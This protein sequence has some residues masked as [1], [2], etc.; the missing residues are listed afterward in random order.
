[1]KMQIIL[2]GLS[3]TLAMTLFIELI[4]AIFKK[5]FHVV[6]ILARM[7]SDNNESVVKKNITYCIA[8]VVHYSI[9]V[10]FAYAFHFLVKQDLIDP[11]L[12][13]ALLFGAL[14]GLVGILGWRMAF[15]LHP[16]P[17]V[18]NRPHYLFV[19]WIGHLIFAMGT[20]IMYVRLSLPPIEA[21]IPVC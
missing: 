11:T 6:R 10:L 20:F 13:H 21:A 12:W 5:P 17:P 14:A 7:L 4:S 18:I 8:V 15:A 1:M 2:S 3:G 9:G 19:I 16:N